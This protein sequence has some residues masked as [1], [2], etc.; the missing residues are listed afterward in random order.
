ME[1]KYYFQSRLVPR[2]EGGRGKLTHWSM[3][4]FRE[5]NKVKI[6]C[7][8]RLKLTTVD[9]KVSFF[10]IMGCFCGGFNIQVRSI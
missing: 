3:R 7:K 6:V 5:V 4:W 8:K 2:G 10:E 9:D 1:E